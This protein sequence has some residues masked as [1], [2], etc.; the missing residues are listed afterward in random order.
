M[1]YMVVKARLTTRHR[2][3]PG[4]EIDATEFEEGEVE[5]LLEAGVIEE[6]ESETAFTDEEFD[7]RYRASPAPNVI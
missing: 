4:T 6:L 3:Q 2:L 1:K 5:P 7:E